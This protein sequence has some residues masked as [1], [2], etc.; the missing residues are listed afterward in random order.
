MVT[1]LRFVYEISNIRSIALPCIQ[2]SVYS[3]NLDNG[4][5][6]IWGSAKQLI[7]YDMLNES[8][9]K[10]NALTRCGKIGTQRAMEYVICGEFDVTV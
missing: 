1:G 2:D 9:K 5:L 6:L 10:V 4:K 3:G 7:I 8:Y